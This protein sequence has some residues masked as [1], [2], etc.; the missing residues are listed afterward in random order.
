MT[1]TPQTTINVVLEDRSGEMHVLLAPDGDHIVTKFKTD[2]AGREIEVH[3]PAE[4]W[5]WYRAVL[6][7]RQA[8]VFL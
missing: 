8:E 3:V 7:A 6:R 2:K 1:D 4:S 5:A